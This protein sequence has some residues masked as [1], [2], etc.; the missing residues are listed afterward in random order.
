LVV[1]INGTEYTLDGSLHS[2]YGSA[3]NQGTHTGE[4]RITHNGTLVAR[5]YGDAN[6]LFS[7]EVLSAM[8]PF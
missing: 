3:G 4:V 2:V 5:V 6:G 8:T 7:V 1:A